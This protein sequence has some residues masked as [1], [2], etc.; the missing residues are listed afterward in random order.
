MTSTAA[1]AAGA[2]SVGIA[3][4]TAAV[5]AAIGTGVAGIVR[6]L[7]NDKHESMSAY[8]PHDPEEKCWILAIEKGP[9][10]VRVLRF[11][12]ECDARM[13]FHKSWSIRVLYNPDGKEV[14]T[15]G[16]NPWARGT[17]RRVMKNAYFAH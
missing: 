1:V 13:R 7:N 14:A 12:S 15:A 11:N 4:S 5:S 6:D 8:E 10:N 3:V 2:V 9:G 17:I 16:W